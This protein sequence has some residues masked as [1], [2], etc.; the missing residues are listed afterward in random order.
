MIKRVENE[1]ELAMFNGIW[2]TVWREKGYELEFAEHV[3][4]RFVVMNE[5]GYCVGTSEIKPYDRDSSPLNEIAPFRDHPK[6][7]ASEGRVAEI[8]KI[9]ILG[10][11]RG[12]GNMLPWILSSAVYS[13]EQHDMDYFVSLLEPVFLRALKISF[14]V[15]V[16]RLGERLFYKGDYVVPVLFDM[17]AM[18]LNKQRYEWLSNP[19]AINTTIEV[20]AG[21]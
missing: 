12:K 6:V 16:E 2:T 14:K 17:S 5:E 4:D 13:A 21:S 20:K 8:D 9:A 10:S 18:Y 15:P 1:L 3:L 11:Y 19:E 7:I